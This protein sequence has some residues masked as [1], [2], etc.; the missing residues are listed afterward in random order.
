[1]NDCDPTADFI[2]SVCQ[3]VSA[4]KLAARTIQSWIATTAVT[5]TE[6]RLLWALLSASDATAQPQTR[7]ARVLACSP[8]QISGSCERLRQLG[9]AT[10]VASATDRR[11][12]CWQLTVSGQRFLAE[13]IGRISAVAGSADREAA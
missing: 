9:L 11:R 6:F 12:Q 1:M 3:Q 4:G 13:I 10:P 2:A 5:D 7:L 8:A